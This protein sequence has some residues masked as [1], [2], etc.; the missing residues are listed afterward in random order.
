MSIEIEDIRS[1]NT[2]CESKI[3]EKWSFNTGRRCPHVARYLINEICVCGT[4]KNSLLKKLK[5]EG[6]ENLKQVR[7]NKAE[8]LLQLIE[9]LLGK[10]FTLIEVETLIDK[11]AT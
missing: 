1:E 2:Q 6:I 3:V 11:Q 10:D 4:H 9:S 8:E 7:R 5:K